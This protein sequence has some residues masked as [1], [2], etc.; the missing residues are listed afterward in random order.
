MKAV[1]EQQLSPSQILAKVNH[2]LYVD[3][4]QMMFVTLFCGAL[5][6]RT[7]E[8]QY[9]NAGHLPPLR[10]RASGQVDWVELP[11][12]TVLGISEPPAY[13]TRTLQLDPGDTLLLY[14]DGVN[15]AMNR[16]KQLFGDDRLRAFARTQ[17]STAPKDLIEGLFGAVHGFAGGEEQS[18]DITV[19]AVRYLGNKSAGGSGSGR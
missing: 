12:G 2:E 10:L 11:K 17:T 5:D 1:A 6:V 19:L 8:L 7:G 9:T 13:T 14:T 4:E 18:D 15:E 3:N 16:E